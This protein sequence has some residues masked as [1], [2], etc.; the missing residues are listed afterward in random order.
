MQFE[1]DREVRAYSNVMELVTD[2]EVIKLSDRSVVKLYEGSGLLLYF[3][4]GYRG[5]LFYYVRLH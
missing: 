1:G 3:T 5:L 2:R 4:V